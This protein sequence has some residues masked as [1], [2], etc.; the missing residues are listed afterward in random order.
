MSIEAHLG[1]DVVYLSSIVKVR[2]THEPSYIGLADMVSS[3]KP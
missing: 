3:R 2:E 1:T